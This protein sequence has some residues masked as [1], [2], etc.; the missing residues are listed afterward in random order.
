MNFG[1]DAVRGLGRLILSRHATLPRFLPT[2]L[3]LR[4]T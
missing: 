1:L 3:V 4:R 2:D